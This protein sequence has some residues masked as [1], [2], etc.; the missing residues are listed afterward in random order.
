MGPEAL[1]LPVVRPSVCVCVIGGGISP[2]GLPSTSSL[3]L[4]TKLAVF[5]RPIKN[6]FSGGPVERPAVSANSPGKM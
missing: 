6:P 2:M 4:K 1:C 5:L 3:Y